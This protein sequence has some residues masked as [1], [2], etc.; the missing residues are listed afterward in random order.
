MISQN[1]RARS[2]PETS[3]RPREPARN[4]ISRPPGREGSVGPANLEGR[5]PESSPRGRRAFTPPRSRR[6]LPLRRPPGRRARAQRA[7]QSTSE[8]G[9]PVAPVTFSANS[10][11]LMAAPWPWRHGPWRREPCRGPLRWSPKGLLSPGQSPPRQK[12]RRDQAEPHRHRGRHGFLRRPKAS[13]GLSGAP[14]AADPQM[15]E[16]HVTASP[17]SRPM[18][19]PPRRRRRCPA[20]LQ[21]VMFRTASS[22]RIMTK[23]R[24]GPHSPVEC[25]EKLG[26]PAA[27]RAKMRRIIGNSRPRPPLFPADR[28]R[29]ALSVSSDR[30]ADPPSTRGE[31]PCA[32]RI[33]PLP[34]LV[35]LP[36]ARA[37]T[38]SAKP[39]HAPSPTPRR[40]SNNLHKASW[41][42]RSDEF[43]V[44]Q[45]LN[46][47]P[48]DVPPPQDP[49]R[50]FY[51]RW[52]ADSTRGFSRGRLDPSPKTVWRR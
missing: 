17:R 16:S 13:F 33:R 7:P 14:A 10:G 22:P 36:P 25:G 45:Q 12:R 11:G 49:R 51:R 5:A 4:F 39:L 46:I 27:N 40:A 35:A 19:R 23:L 28:R 2:S 43:T 26:G 42:E 1:K 20:A 34:P 32:L 41:T 52:R 8:R 29:R 38:T 15:S 44:R 48:L 18:S 50:S 37:G 47:V 30:T 3:H 21:S 24:L 9:L 31:R 6:G